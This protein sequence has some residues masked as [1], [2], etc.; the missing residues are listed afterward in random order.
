MKS[1]SQELKESRNHLI[2]LLS[3]GKNLDTSR[4]DLTEIV[5]QYFRNGLQESKVGN[6]LFKEKRPF[7]FVAVGGYGREE[8]C[9][10]SDID[11]MIL[12]GYLILSMVF[13]IKHFWK[14]ITNIYD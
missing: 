10:H 12:F 8:L 2:S 1:P 4:G 6:R 3:N 14:F 5:D 11:L 9:V 13:R 7:A